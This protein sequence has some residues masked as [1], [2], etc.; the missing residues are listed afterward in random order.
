VV[1]FNKDA[2]EYA[3]WLLYASLAILIIP[4]SVVNAYKVWKEAHPEIIKDQQ[5]NPSKYVTAHIC[6]INPYPIESKQGNFIYLNTC[7]CNALFY[8]VRLASLSGYAVV[9]N[10]QSR[11]FPKI[12]EEKAVE[13]KRGFTTRDLRLNATDEFTDELRM[14][15]STIGGFKPIKIE[16]KLVGYDGEHREYPLSAIYERN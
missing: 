16:L 3:P 10:K 9:N 12:T 11:N 2:V 15:I 5:E 1:Y 4:F 14:S 6:S 8:D 7:F 13:I